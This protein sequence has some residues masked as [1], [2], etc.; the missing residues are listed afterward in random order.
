MPRVTNTKGPTRLWVPKS[1]I[2]FADMLISQSICHNAWTTDDCVIQQEENICSYP[3]SERGRIVEVWRI[4]K[5]E[6]CGY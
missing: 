2:V 5:K 1:K 6:Y 3:N 4:A